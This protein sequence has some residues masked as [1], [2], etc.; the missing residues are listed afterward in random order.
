M[1]QLMNRIGK[2]LLLTVLM[3]GM[4]CA[5]P[6]EADAQRKKPVNKAAK[7][8][9]V[10]N[11]VRHNTTNR[12]VAKRR[13]RKRYVKRHVVH[14]TYRGFPRR[15]AIVRTTP[16]GA[17]VVNFKR[18]RYHYHGG[19][20]YVAATG[21]FKVVRPVLGIRVRVLPTA[22]RRI[23]VAGHSRPYYYYGGVFYTQETNDAGEEEYEVAK[24]PEGAVVDGL[25]E[26]YETVA[27]AGEDYYE[28]DD[29]YYRPVE[30][31]EFDE[32]VGYEVVANPVK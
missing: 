27:V 29:V 30:A 11:A 15:G 28:L 12:A 31:E 6:G 17:V 19:V 32:G 25:P 8:R 5:L 1:K 14:R 26:G 18:Q 9:A 23:V 3:T 20:F 13:V 16:G 24:A 21:G 2:G 10:K 7:K 22:R 4:F